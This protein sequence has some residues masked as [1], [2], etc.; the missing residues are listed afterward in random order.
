MRLQKASR[1]ALYAATEL[2]R[3]PNRQLSAAE[4]AAIYD[5]SLNHLAKILR[6]L[7]RAGMVEA[8]RGVGGGYRFI[9]N[10]KRTSLYDIIEL[11]EEPAGE[12][13]NSGLEG[14]KTSVG[15]SLI[16]VTTEIDLIAEATLRSISLATLLRDA[17]AA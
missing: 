14:A 7:G 6:E 5:I 3:D 12:V 13:S 10:P 8:V 2:A 17:E 9:A 15:K 1:Y 16:A 11:F 4:I